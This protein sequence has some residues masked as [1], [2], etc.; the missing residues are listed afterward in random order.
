MEYWN[1]ATQILQAALKQRQTHNTSNQYPNN[2]VTN[3]FDLGLALD[4]AGK[5]NNAMHSFNELIEGVKLRPYCTSINNN[6]VSCI[7]HNINFYQV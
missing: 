5:Y 2:L 4:K 7:L 1:K 6:N 3:L